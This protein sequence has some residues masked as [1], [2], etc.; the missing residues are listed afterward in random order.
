M[1]FELFRSITSNMGN[2]SKCYLGDFGGIVV[3]QISLDD[4]QF[5]QMHSAIL[6]NTDMIDLSCKI[7]T[8]A[9]K[10]P[11]FICFFG[12][13]AEFWHDQFDEISMIFKNFE[14]PI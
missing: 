8:I 5:I 13:N 11:S 10:M 4:I 2:S 14:Y 1:F 7:Q 9:R 3:M 6:V 12:V